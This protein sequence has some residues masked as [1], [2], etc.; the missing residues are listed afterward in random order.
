MTPIARHTDPQTSHAAAASKTTAN[1]RNS[2]HAVLRLFNDAYQEHDI[3]GMTD[4]LLVRAYAYYEYQPRQSPSGIRT[5][6]REL[7]D[8][9][10]LIDT[11]RREKLVSGRS[12]IVWALAKPE[13][14]FA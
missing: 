12:A 1:V 13:A 14:L 9:G 10:Y 3:A 5:R 8:A 4:E 2:Q 7:C 6:R 11:G